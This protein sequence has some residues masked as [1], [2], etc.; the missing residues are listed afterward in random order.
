[1]LWSF[2]ILFLSYLLFINLNMAQQ[3][4]LVV[5]RWKG[6]VSSWRTEKPLNL[7]DNILFHLFLFDLFICW[8]VNI[9]G[10]LWTFC[11]YLVIWQ[12]SLWALRRFVYLMKIRHGM[13]TVLACEPTENIYSMLRNEEWWCF[14][15][16]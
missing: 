11:T 2:I 5:S 14:Q 6:N 7:F 16:K 4:N 8:R 12:L 13:N 3:V 15:V 1:M 10:E 9:I